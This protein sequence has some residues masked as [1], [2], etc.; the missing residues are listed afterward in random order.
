MDFPYG[1]AGGVSANILSRPILR[2]DAT[3]FPA[4]EQLQTPG[5]LRGVT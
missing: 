1:W 5:Y 3:I 4:N 2:Y